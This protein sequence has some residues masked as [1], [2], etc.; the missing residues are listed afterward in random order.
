MHI[1][2][3]LIEVTLHGEMMLPQKHMGLHKSAVL[4][5]GYVRMSCCSGEVPENPL[6][7][8]MAHAFDG[9]KLFDKDAIHYNHQTEKSSWGWSGTSLPASLHNVGWYNAIISYSNAWPDEICSL[10]QQ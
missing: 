4:G 6:D 8:T 5:T 1:C 10:F 9:K 2:L 7:N 3:S